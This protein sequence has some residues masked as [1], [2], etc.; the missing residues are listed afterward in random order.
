MKSRWI[1]AAVLVLAGASQA[2]AGSNT[3]RE[4]L[5]LD[6]LKDRPHSPIIRADLDCGSDKKSC[7]QG[8][9]SRGAGWSC[10]YVAEWNQWCLFPPGH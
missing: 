3:I 6:R 4:A 10:R 8:A 9:E 2:A 5:L 7:T 1:I